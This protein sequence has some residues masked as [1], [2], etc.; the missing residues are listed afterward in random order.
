MIALTSY[1]LD[2][3]AYE[4]DCLRGVSL[5]AQPRDGF[6]KLCSRDI[7]NQNK[8][9][10]Q[11]DDGPWRLGISLRLG[12]DADAL[13]S[14]AATQDL[15]RQ[16]QT[17]DGSRQASDAYFTIPSYVASEM[18]NIMPIL[19]VQAH[20][21]NLI[22]RVVPKGSFPYHRTRHMLPSRNLLLHDDL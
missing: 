6:Q 15:C 3:R 19:C 11:M 18:V 12:G 21:I 22:H 20:F 13:A 4:A 7:N 10:R 5:Q 14:T 2:P 9:L 1:C 8:G 17:P 16:D